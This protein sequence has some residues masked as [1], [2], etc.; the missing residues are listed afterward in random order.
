MEALIGEEVY[1][2][3]SKLNAKE[4]FEGGAWEW[5]Q[6]Y[7]YWY[8]SGCLFPRMATCFMALDPSTRENACLEVLKCSHL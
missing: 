4:P 3:N 5:H 7:G 8:A 1:H 6:D 2:Y